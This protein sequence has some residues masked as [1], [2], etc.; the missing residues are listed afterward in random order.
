MKNELK[1][2]PFCGGQATLEREEN[3]D[4]IVWCRCG[5]VLGA[6]GASDE[7]E[8]AWNRRSR[9]DRGTV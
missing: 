4:W 7:A 9:N 2:C 3:D 6:F 1:P 5:C 8:T